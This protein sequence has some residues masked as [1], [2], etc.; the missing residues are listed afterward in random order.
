MPT[1]SERLP[2]WKGLQTDRMP[3]FIS[4]SQA[5][6]MV[7]SLID[8]ISSWQPAAVVAIVRGGL[9]PGTMTSCTLA[10]PLFMISWARAT[11]V[12]NWIGPLPDEKRV[13]LVDDCCATGQTMTSVKAALHNQGYE[14]ATLTIVHDPET[15]CYVPDFSHPMTELFRFPWERGEATPASRQLRA[16]GPAADRATERPFYGLGLD[17]VFLPDLPRSDYVT[18]LTDAIRRR[19]DLALCPVLPHFAPERAVII[20]ARPEVDRVLTTSWLTRWGFEDLMLECRP[21]D[22]ADDT[23]SV[24][25]YKAVTATRWGCTHFVESDPE[26]AIRIAAHAPHLVVNWWS[27]AEARA[28]MIGA[29]AQN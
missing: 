24:A 5:E 1:S 10:L 6:R 4:Y 29:S 2:V 16:T 20:T 14:C 25:R 15:T 12:T 26:Q 23:S 21:P 27:V 17:G 13:L 19:H 22:V 9:I 28:W 8:S 11:N 3:G 18:D 7:G